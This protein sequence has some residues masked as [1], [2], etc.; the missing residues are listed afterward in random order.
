LDQRLTFAPHIEAV[1]KKATRSAA[2]LARLMPNVR[3]PCQWKRR[4]LASVVESQLLYAA[5]IWADKVASV[6]RTR[7]K[8]VRPQRTAALRVIRAYRILSDEAALLLANMLPAD[9]ISLEKSRIRDRLTA[10]P[11]PGEPRTSKAI[12]KRV[13]RQVTIELWQGRWDTTDKGAWTRRVL[14]DVRRWLGRTVTLSFH[15]T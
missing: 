8:L 15:M 4:L 7:A 1:A 3:G 10:A 5:P 6:E 12:V 11:T 9:L 2:A 14:P 13:E